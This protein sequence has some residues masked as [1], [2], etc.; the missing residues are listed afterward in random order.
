ML[1]AFIE[2]ERY[3]SVSVLT[4]TCDYLRS[5]SPMLIP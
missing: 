1:D 2:I 3:Q 5:C 4:R